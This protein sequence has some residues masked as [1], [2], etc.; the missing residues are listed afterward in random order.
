MRGAMMTETKRAVWVGMLGIHNSGHLIG[1]WYDLRDGEVPTTTEAWMA[2]PRNLTAILDEQVHPY[3]IGDEV[4]C[5]DIEGFPKNE[6]MS[7]GQAVEIHEE[8]EEAAER[9]C[10]DEDVIVAALANDID[11]ESQDFQYCGLWDSFQE[12]AEELAD[13]IYPRPPEAIQESYYWT[14]D[15]EMFARDLQGDY[16]VV[17]TE[18]YQVHVFQAW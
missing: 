13:D 8:I 18:G 9:H 17:D 5:F 7:P 4:W 10:V 14:F 16:T 3:D 6:E 1:Q 11:V 12:Y 2:D 15:Y